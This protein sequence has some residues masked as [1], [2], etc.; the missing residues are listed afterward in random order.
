MEAL[1]PI[2]FMLI[3]L[4]ILIVVIAGMWKV[5]T[6][7]GQ[8][9]WAAIIPIVNLYFLLKIARRP[10]WWLVLFFVPLVNVI[11]GIV[12]ALDIARNFGK[13]GGF[14]VGL[15]FLPFIFYPILGFGDAQYVGGQEGATEVSA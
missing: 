2:L 14:A 9:G 15:I 5:F 6:K 8:P 11:I 7:A 1:V 10:G 3:W 13:G 4:A 12:M